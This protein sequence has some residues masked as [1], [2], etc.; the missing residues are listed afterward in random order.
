MK[1][2]RALVT[3]LWR[4]QRREP[5]GLFFAFAFAPALVLILG[6]IFGNE[7]RPEF[8]GRGMLDSGLP[9]FASLVLAMTGVL[10][11]PVSLLTLRD[12]GALRRLELTPLRRSTFVAATLTVNFLV[13]MVGMVAALLVGVVVFQ[14]A[15]PSTVLG[16]LLAC[17][18]G[19]VVFLALGFALAGLYPSVGAATGIGNVLM[20]LLMLTSGAWTP[21]A[22]LP[23]GVR[24]VFAYS[25]VRWFVELVQPLWDGGATS[26][27]PLLL[28]AGLLVVSALVGRLLF[29]WE[30]TR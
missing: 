23:E 17:A 6:L 21:I 18:F 3:A 25:P 24:R 12:T 9:G 22:V 29:R 7:P 27:R 10:Q 30:P 11:V 2:Y 1:A 20:I 8:G 5:V 15:L 4:S 16:V 26:A 28:L 13:G 14:V 19:L